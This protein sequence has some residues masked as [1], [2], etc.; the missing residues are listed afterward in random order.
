LTNHIPGNYRVK[1]ILNDAVRD[2]WDFAVSRDASAADTPGRDAPALYARGIFGVGIEPA[3]TGDAF[4]DYDNSLS[5][6]LLEAVRKE[7]LG[8]ARELFAQVS[9]G[10]VIIQF[11]LG[12]KGTVSSPRILSNSLTNPLGEFFLRALQHGAPYA[13]W[14]R[15]ALALQGSGTRTMKVT[16]SCD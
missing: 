8:S 12:S 14:P 2:T 4:V 1:L 3:A 15:E 16:F 6:A 7:T 9:P 5:R 13:V 10:E 11:E